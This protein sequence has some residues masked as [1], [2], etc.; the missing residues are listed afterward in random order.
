MSDTS[1]TASM[2]VVSFVAAVMS[3][4][5]I[6]RLFVAVYGLVVLCITAT[7][8][9][10]SPVPW[11]ILLLFVICDTIIVFHKLR[12]R[13]ERGKAENGP[14]MQL[15]L[16]VPETVTKT[17][18][19]TLRAMGP[20]FVGC[21]ASLLGWLMMMAVWIGTAVPIDGASN[22]L[23]AA[24]ALT[25]CCAVFEISVRMKTHETCDTRKY[26]G[27]E[28]FV[29]QTFLVHPSVAMSMVAITAAVG[30]MLFDVPLAVTYALVVGAWPWVMVTG[31]RV[32][33]RRRG[34]NTSPSSSF[35]WDA[36]MTSEV[37][38]WATLLMHD[39]RRVQV[40]LPQARN[41]AATL[42]MAIT[43]VCFAFGA[44]VRTLMR[45]FPDLLRDA[46]PDN[47]RDTPLPTTKVVP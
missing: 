27:V 37:A 26:P 1:V 44:T 39:L 5:P 14:L 45:T 32:C 13:S 29:I 7:S 28:T 34:R 33:L 19:R 16:G 35:M 22:V 21:Y 25:A 40:V 31:I 18:M 24:I 2:V 43:S 9:T 42:A 23:S 30:V 46:N 8:Y 17:P 15:L 12:Y 3:V 36:R 41:D 11:F 20:I 10:T 6:T 4:S 47:W 38:W